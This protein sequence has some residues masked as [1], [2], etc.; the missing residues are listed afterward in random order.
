MQRQ[1]IAILALG[2][3]ILATVAG[4]CADGSSDA[5]AL[6]GE[7]LLETASGTEAILTLNSDGRL[8]RVTIEFDGGQIE[9]RVIRGSADVIL[10]SVRITS[11]LLTGSL[12]FEGEISEGGDEIVGEST[13]VLAL[14]L[15]TIR[16]DAEPATLT[17]IS[18]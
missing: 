10:D 18:D 13:I 2:L 15:T 7:W 12:I 8:S 9:T 14:P 3:S 17:R 1:P 4:G 16:L 11:T 5:S 6:E